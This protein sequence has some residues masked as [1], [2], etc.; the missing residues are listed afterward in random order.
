MAAGQDKE[1]I[2]RDPTFERELAQ[3]LNRHSRENDSGTPDFILARFMQSALDAFN[4]ATAT[5]DH[6]YG[7][8]NLPGGSN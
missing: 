2:E 5:R 3:L 6:W 1:E 8:T 4:K 7:K